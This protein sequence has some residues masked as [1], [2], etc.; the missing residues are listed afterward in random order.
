MNQPVSMREQLENYSAVPVK[1]F[2]A[3]EDQKAINREL[4]I[5]NARLHSALNEAKDELFR[6]QTQREL[7]VIERTSA[8][9]Q[10]AVAMT[11]LTAAKANIDSAIERD[12]KSQH[13]ERERKQELEEKLRSSETQARLTELAEEL[14]ALEPNAVEEVGRSLP[15]QAGRFPHPA[16]GDAYTSV[17]SDLAE[18]AAALERARGSHD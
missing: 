12:L 4:E 15:A 14:A 2:D 1:L 11:A 17:K 5:E 7:H 8:Q 10:F 3:L 13:E 9:E 6:L 16:L 18:N